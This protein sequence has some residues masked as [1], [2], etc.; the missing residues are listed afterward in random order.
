MDLIRIEGGRPADFLDV[1]G[2][3]KEE[4]VAKAFRILV[5]DPQIKAVLVNIFGGIVRGDLVAGGIVEAA[6]GAGPRVPVVIRLEGTNA[7]EGR[8]LLRGSGLAFHPAEGM[9]EAAALAVA[10]AAGKERPGKPE[11]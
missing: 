7:E 3:V 11:P 9:R 5:S 8:A 6:R 4:A 10:L 2:S 1:G